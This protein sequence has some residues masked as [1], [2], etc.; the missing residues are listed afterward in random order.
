MGTL[1]MKRACLALSLLVGCGAQPLSQSELADAPITSA[2]SAIAA[3]FPVS[4]AN[5]DRLVAAAG[6]RY[7]AGDFDGTIAALQYG[8]LYRPFA[9][10]FQSLAMRILSERRDR[11]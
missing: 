9:L 11:L 1:T 8:Q 6:E 2:Q 4:D 10:K 5:A 3:Y 7:A